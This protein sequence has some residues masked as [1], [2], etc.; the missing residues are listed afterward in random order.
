MWWFSH[1]KTTFVNL[2]H[3]LEPAY[4]KPGKVLFGIG[5][6]QEVSTDEDVWFTHNI[7]IYC[8]LQGRAAECYLQHVFKMPYLEL[9]DGICIECAAMIYC[10]R[11]I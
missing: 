1:P 11:L 6:K 3:F 7:S 2:G 5:S 8:V 10:R 4:V 9:G